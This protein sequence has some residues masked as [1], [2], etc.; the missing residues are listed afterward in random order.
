MIKI[1]CESGHMFVKWTASFCHAGLISRD[2]YQGYLFS[3]AYIISFDLFKTCLFRDKFNS[4]GKIQFTRIIIVC[5]TRMQIAL[6]SR[7]RH[8]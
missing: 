6:R 3:R 7:Y 5:V 1:F 8:Y 4:C 2:L